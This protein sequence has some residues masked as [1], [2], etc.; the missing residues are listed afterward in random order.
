MTLP[1]KRLAAA[2][3]DEYLEALPQEQRIALE[4]LRKIIKSLVPKAEEVI[5]YH[6][7]TFKYNGKLVAFA[8]F[9]DHCSFF[10]LNSTLVKELSEDLKDYKTAPGTIQFT[11]NKPLPAALVKKIVVARMKENEEIVLAKEQ[12]KPTAKKP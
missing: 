7:P 11:V 1:T 9:K 2:S 4:K 10:P 5:S 6:I 8:A 12:N 3:I